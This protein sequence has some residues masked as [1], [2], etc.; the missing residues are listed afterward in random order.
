MSPRLP[1]SL[2]RALMLPAELLTA[3]RTLRDIADHTERM[4]RHTAVLGEVVVAL[5]EVS[6]HT[7]ALAGLRSDMA[8]VAAMTGVLEPMDGR[9]AAIEATMPI[10]VDVQKDL[11]RVPD[12]IEHLDR[13][14]DELNGLLGRLLESMQELSASVD[15][16]QGSVGPLGR[17]ARRLPGQR[18]EE[19]RGDE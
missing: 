6:E 7:A 15:Q 12:T 10:L 1:F 9:M 11:T 2:D 8:H 14:I 16:L 19:S 3:L 13:R 17:I 18:R 4:E 5:K